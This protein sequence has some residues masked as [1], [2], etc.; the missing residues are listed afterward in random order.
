M[1]RREASTEL[2]LKLTKLPDVVVDYSRPPIM[3]FHGIWLSSSG[4]CSQRRRGFGLLLLQVFSA[5]TAWLP[6]P[7]KLSTHSRTR[8]VFSSCGLGCFGVECW[9]LLL[10]DLRTDE[11]KS[12]VL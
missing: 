10:E 1:G 9:G 5:L 3:G 6:C 11:P 12:D 4:G 7:T 2:N 8:R